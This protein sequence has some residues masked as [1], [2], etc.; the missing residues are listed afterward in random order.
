MAES[1]LATGSSASPAIEPKGLGKLFIL[2]KDGILANI[3]QRKSGI[4]IKDPI[5]M[6]PIE[7][8]SFS[9]RI[10]IIG[11]DGMGPGR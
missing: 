3:S 4:R 8:I 9:F 1:I 11:I 7:N 6:D 2:F 10:P 5:G